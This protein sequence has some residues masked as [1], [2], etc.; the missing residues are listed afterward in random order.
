M[1]AEVYFNQKHFILFRLYIKIDFRQH[2]F[3]LWNYNIE[4]P[5]DPVT[6]ATSV[7]FLP[8]ER[9]LECKL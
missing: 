3:L 9:L 6:T 1:A 8:L 7:H 5:V 2:S 4:N